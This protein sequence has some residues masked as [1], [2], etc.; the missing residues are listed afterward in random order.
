M[1]ATEAGFADRV[2]ER[3]R[4]LIG[5][6]LAHLL[7]L[8]AEE[9]DPQR[10]F[11]EQGLTSLLCEELRLGLQEQFGPLS[12][13]LLFE[14]P[15]LA[16]LAA[17]LAHMQEPSEAASEAVDW[18]ALANPEDAIAI[19]G[20]A[21]RFP[22][23][24]NAEAFWQLLIEGR[25]C[26]VPIP[27]E[28]W[29]DPTLSR[30]GAL[31][32]ELDRF[33][34]L[35]FQISPAE[36]ERLDPQVKLALMCAWETLEHG[37]FA[38][39]QRRA[40][41]LIGHYI[42]VTW[43][44]FSLLHHE[45]GFL[46]GEYLGPGAHY[47]Q[48]ANRVS[49]AF[50]LGGPSLAV[51]SACS[52]S[53]VAIH[54]ACQALRSGD[55]SLALA[56]G[57]NLSLH[58]SKYA[59]LER[60]GFL[61]GD[62]RCKPFAAAADGYVP[63]E[64]VGYVLLQP[65]AAAQASGAPVLAVIRGSASNHGGR[66]TGY[67]V[68]N[69]RAHAKVIALACQRA[70]LAPSYI[71]Y[72]EAH[73]TGTALGDP[74]EV[75]GLT[76]VLGE[77]PSRSC[78]LGSVKGNIGHL[79][80]AA[81]VAGLI[82]LVLGMR[83]MRLPATVNQ[84]PVSP[85]I[86]FENTRFRLIREAEAWPRVDQV[87]GL[88]SF[89]A[90]GSNAHVIL[91][92]AP[93][94][95]PPAA[96]LA[97]AWVP[98]SAR[99]SAGLRLL[100]MRL[101]DELARCGDDPARWPGFVGSLR[102]GRLAWHY[103]L[104][105]VA[106]NFAACLAALNAF[107]AGTE[108]AW[109]EACLARHQITE[110]AGTEQTSMAQWLAGEVSH[111]NA[112][113]RF[114]WL[115]LPTTPFELERSWLT[116]GGALYEPLPRLF[117]ALHPLLDYADN[118]RERGLYG[119]RF[120]LDCYAL[121]EHHVAGTPL[122]PGV[123]HLE[124][125]WQAA[126]RWT[127]NEALELRDVLFQH[128]IRLLQPELHVQ[129]R[130]EGSGPAL[131][132]A[133][134][135]A[136]DSTH[137]D[138]SSGQVLPAM[139][140]Q[141]ALRPPRPLAQQMAPETLY[142]LFR[143]NGILQ[144]QAFQVVVAFSWNDDEAWAELRIPPSRAGEFSDYALPSP[145]L[146]GAVQ[147]AMAHLFA[148]R[149][150]DC[151]RVPFHLERLQRFG[152]APQ[153]VFASARPRPDHPDRYEVA[154]TDGQGR[155]WILM[156]GL[157]LRPYREHGE[158]DPGRAFHLPS[159]RAIAAPA[160]AAPP[161][162]LLV[163]CSAASWA[164]LSPRLTS[165]GEVHWTGEQAL[166]EAEAPA[167]V[168]ANL[169][170]KG[171]PE[172]L[173]VLGDDLDEAAEAV[174]AVLFHWCQAALARLPRLR[175]I[176]CWREREIKPRHH[177]VTGLLRSLTL[178]H[179]AF[180]GTTLCLDEASD[181]IKALQETLADPVSV[182]VRYQSGQRQL[183][184]WSAGLPT[185][186]Q[187]TRLVVPGQHYLITGGLGGLGQLFA[188]AMLAEGA[189]LTLFGRTVRALDELG[190]CLG[191]DYDATR[192][193]YRAVDLTQPVELGEQLAAACAQ[194][195]PLRGVLHAAGVLDDGFLSHKR[196]PA[197]ARV[198]APKVA[199]TEQLDQACAEQPLDYF[200]MFSSVSGV[201]GNLGQADYAYANA[202]QDAYAELREDMRGRGLRHGRSLAIAWPY[203]R[204]GGMRLD[205]A[206]Q[207]QLARL[208][209]LHGLESAHGLR[210]CREIL[211]GTAARVLVMEGDRDRIRQVLGQLE[212]GSAKTPKLEAGLACAGQDPHE[213]A[214]NWLCELVGAELKLSTEQLDPHLPLDR[215]GLDSITLIGLSERLE[216]HLGAL[217]RTLFFEWENL[218]DGANWLVREHG[219]RFQAPTAVPEPP[220]ALDRAGEPAQDKGDQGAPE[221]IAIIGMTARL[222]L[223]ADLERFWENLCAGRDCIGE[224]PASRWASEAYYREDGDGYGSTR[225][226]W[227]GFLEDVNAFDAAFFRI[228]P[229][230]AKL[231]DPEE[232]L[233]LEQT[234]HTLE[235]A[236]LTRADLEA[237][238]R[239][240]GGEVGVYVGC[241][242]RHYGLLE[243]DAEDQPRLELG[244]YWWLANR[245]SWLYDLQGPSMAIDTACASA[246]TAVHLACESLARGECGMAFAGAVNLSL[247]PH[248]Y[249]G[250]NQLGLLASGRQSRGLGT[251]DG[252]IPGEGV[253][254]LLL[255][256]YA[257]ALED[258]DRVRA[259]IR[260]SFANHGGHTS[261]LT[262]PNARAHARLW[263]RLFER[264]GCQPATIGYVETA[265][266]GSALG[267]ALELAG[268]ARAFA[269][270]ELPAAS[271]AIGTVK[272]NLGHLEAASGISQLAK[273]VLQLEHRWLVPTIHAEPLNPNLQ[274]ER[275]PFALVREGRPW[276]E[277]GR[278]RALVTSI[279]AGGTNTALIVDAAPILL[280]QPSAVGRWVFP[281]SARSQAALDRL[282]GALIDWLERHPEAA[283]DQVAHTLQIGREAFAERLAVVASEHTEL[284]AKLRIAV[285]GEGISEPSTGETE[286]LAR[287]WLA[288]EQVDWRAS[289]A[290]RPRLSLPLYPFERIG[291]GP[292]C[293]VAAP[294][295]VVQDKLPSPAMDTADA[296]GEAA[297][298]S[299]CVGEPGRREDALA[300]VREQVLVVLGISPDQELESQRFEDLGI[301]SFLAL[302]L[303]RAFERVFGKLRKTLFFETFSIDELTDT[304]LREHAARLFEQLKPEQTLAT[305]TSAAP[306]ATSSSA[307]WVLRQDQVE[308]EPE[309]RALMSGLERWQDEFTA[310][311]A[312][313]EIAPLLFI[314]AERA[315]CFPFN[316]EG[317][318]VL[319]FGYLGPPEQYEALLEE[320]MSYCQA[321]AL[322]VALIGTR[323]IA[324]VAGRRF[325]ATPFGVMQRLPPLAEFSLEGGAMR[326]LRYMVQHCQ[327]EGEVRTLSYQPGSDPAVDQAIVDLIDRWSASKSM[328]N[329]LV[330]KTRAEILSAS[331]PRRHRIFISYQQERPLN[332]IIVSRLGQGSWLMDLEFYPPHMTLGG[333]ETTIVQIAEILRGEGASQLS[334][335]ATWGALVGTSA[336]ACPEWLAQLGELHQRG[337]FNG[338]GNLQFKN[339][340]RP[341]NQDIFLCRPEGQTGDITDIILMISQP[342]EAP[343]EEEPH[344]VCSGDRA[345][346]AGADMDRL[347][348]LAQHG[349]N[350]MRLPDDRVEIDLV[351]DS[352]SQLEQDFI[353]VRLSEL[354]SQLGEVC[355]PIAILRGIFPFQHLTLVGSGRMAE[356]FLCDALPKQSSHV[357][358][359]LLFPTWIVHQIGNGFTPV[360]LPDARAFDHQD[361]FIFKGNLDLEGVR[362]RLDQLA[363]AYC[364]VELGNNATGGYPVSLD[365]LRQLRALLAPRGI[366]LLLDGTRILENAVFIQRHEAGCQGDSIWKI[367]GDICA[368]AD[369]MT[370]SLCKD[371]C[372]NVGGFVATN[373]GALHAQIQ[374]ATSTR[375]S[376][377]SAIDRRLIG[378]G[379]RG[380]ATIERLV[381][382]RMAA[383]ARLHADLAGEGVPVLHPHGGHCVV[384]DVKRLDPHG[385]E[386]NPLATTLAWLYLHT[387]IRAGAHSVGMQRQSSLN[388]LV[389]LAL[390]VGLPEARVAEIG[391]AMVK[392]FRQ[393]F[394][395]PALVHDRRVP[396]LFGEARATY[397]LERIEAEVTP[398]PPPEQA[399]AAPTAEWVDPHESIAIVGLAGRYP[400]AENL[401]IFWRNLVE[402][403]DCVTAMPGDRWN[404]RELAGDGV[405]DGHLMGGFIDGVTC[406][407]ALFFNISPREARRMDPQERLFLEIAWET[408]EEAGYTPES[409]KQGCESDQIG[410][411]VGATWSMYQ[412]LDADLA[413]SGHGVGANSWLWAIANRVSYVMG[414]GGPSLV[415]D[416]ACSSSLA[417]L[418]MARKAILEGSCTAALAGGV[419]L[420]LHPA[421]RMIVQEAGFLAED[422]RC[423]AFGRGGSGYVPGE[424]VGAVLLRRLSLA[425]RD[426][427]HIHAVIRSSTM[428][429]GGRT[430]GFTV[431]NTLAQGELVR[432]ALREA[433]TPAASI[434]YLEAHGTGTA[435]GDPIEV[436]G[437]CQAF[438]GDADRHGYCALGSVK[439]NIG[440]LE[441]A[442]GIAGL[443][444]VLLQMRHRLIAPSLH[445]GELNEY[446]DF[447]NSP[448]FVPQRTCPWQPERDL[449]EGLPPR[450]GISSFGAGGANVHLILEAAPP[451]SRRGGEGGPV[452]LVYSARS[453]ERLRMLVV[454]HRDYLAKGLSRG[455]VPDLADMAFTLQTGRQALSQRLAVV[456]VDAAVALAQLEAYLSGLPATAERLSGK[457]RPNHEAQAE[458]EAAFESRDLKSLARL[459]VEGVTLDWRRL[460]DA[461]RRLSLPTYPFAR[462]PHWLGEAR[463]AGPPA[464]G[465]V[466]KPSGPDRLR[467]TLSASAAYI[468]DHCVGGQHL[469][470]GVAYLELARAA[471]VVA[472]TTPT[473]LSRIAW[474][475]PLRL[476]Q[477]EVA[478]EV[479]LESS[480]E[481]RLAFTV[482]SADHEHARG[483]LDVLPLAPPQALDLAALERRLDT[484]ESGA[485][486]YARFKACGFDY[487]PSF[488]AI[489]RLHRRG[490]EAL[491]L[492]AAPPAIAAELPS[493]VCHPSFLD[494]CLHLVIALLPQDGSPHLPYGLGELTLYRDLASAR[495][496]HIWASGE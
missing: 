451:L 256:P 276:S 472:G 330:P 346:L 333:L 465:L 335:G 370:A 441:A 243:H 26:A 81:G 473:C 13:T 231:M 210:A 486:C 258:G 408:L 392:A 339:K 47:W 92:A 295:A 128:P 18:E 52:S 118:T 429:H 382:A 442:A 111:F 162:R 444:K 374:A 149:G 234:W 28:R 155:P 37:N 340:F 479:R 208:F 7:G 411:Y 281:L 277:A 257:R 266:N 21:C 239:R 54:L 49:F 209:G 436:E 16:A 452:L 3:C 448:F 242:Y 101:R 457:A 428:N 89:G 293:V 319:V 450:A 158:L 388:D 211:A 305:P 148:T 471:A 17:H 255:K 350:P 179:P 76:E 447:D 309:A 487:G 138:Y 359:N 244:S 352:W 481:G 302:K 247:H 237:Y 122:L 253:G 88:S 196:W 126:A 384:I 78:G 378:L 415:V 120:G 356:S 328:V 284:L 193:S 67:T 446:I 116:S 272:S 387:G 409:L 300:W 494:S 110:Q 30:H 125:A 306:T 44:E 303:V 443:T 127:G 63:G 56:G 41:Q 99:S 153:K 107:L 198:L 9:L 403:R 461:G 372:L 64:G 11:Y 390:P 265:A 393:P 275:T 108:G 119:K 418:H 24:A 187:P 189:S 296:T 279:G 14:H 39:P 203:W 468:R 488:Q 142:G 157:G 70:G 97:A 113:A 440:H 114:P 183:L 42:G 449:R 299:V 159:W 380:R 453:E 163:H 289:L 2:S 72:I 425:L 278:W 363:V 62:G 74:V 188:R 61:A 236:A 135:P 167:R 224:V 379:L 268:L 45:R 367:V 467:C 65:L 395:V 121:K 84:E 377:L 32:E 36:A 434:T 33:D 456:C 348:L 321:Q 131:R 219:Q 485:S 112:P 426:G 304:L 82:K 438:R 228:A 144:K 109:Q 260:G 338:H 6:R 406:F 397:R 271:V 464:P 273:V 263:R 201:L 341:S 462:V 331:L 87:A 327:R 140:E 482:S 105:L 90:G 254:M 423:R 394:P 117:T 312:T 171:T 204:Q 102:Y 326:R 172:V 317:D 160:A 371:F 285:I 375:G 213:R 51:D 455:Q 322:R 262:V 407:D 240:P 124:M 480:G 250:L 73:G 320:L 301:D 176:H 22:Q 351:T 365:N 75:R 410:V 368:L 412:L 100:A 43:H 91:T 69:P 85:R 354:Q 424:G 71:K 66:A 130:V 29:H 154:L 220:E 230:E 184:G 466:F 79:E 106:D 12:S 492:L 173:L 174:A 383:V 169:E 180:V 332:T 297:R 259:V 222:P 325:T 68:P 96:A 35:F 104:A 202:F 233:L 192:V 214:L 329:P 401:D 19:V 212:V 460:G 129:C 404:Y 48:V 249:L 430:A 216:P 50:D 264:S 432:R 229:T 238:Q 347:A 165:W 475:R 1:P 206:G 477:G 287:R 310:S 313:R 235:D 491:A 46:A 288:G 156:E 261:G 232:R 195:G 389:R 427:D 286:A 215:F 178:E 132:F 361:P 420:D 40:G 267:D 223:A 414:F 484:V 417:A 364:C 311:R 490:R 476:E 398:H 336:N 190:Q 495:W 283:L 59:W 166:G 221:G 38:Q 139:A 349:Y 493:L 218:I 369:G 77:T 251:G 146:D 400:M 136:Q 191:A 123:C 360:E 334:L 405:P 80:A 413:R 98:V 316:R 27:S 197:F 145:L 8:P 225:Q 324:A 161:A 381:R 470:P 431:P 274:L 53:L 152:P 175:L 185:A 362:Q 34:P 294:A 454:R 134:V 459:W 298:A 323:A 115:N 150:H 282:T 433:G 95:E 5:D 337:V 290:S 143:E 366:P 170:P 94:T 177:A 245:I 416:T 435:L 246:L 483:Q 217:P 373:D 489:E 25:D 181:L 396:G 241:M 199:G 226:K 355:D 93:L 399:V 307:P 182:Q 343:S 291:H 23:A 385:E 86:P 419:N 402:G 137:Y 10:S 151:L 308:S 292:G 474:L 353:R 168:L 60:S 345:R 186:A 445:S 358:Q 248:K 391:T 227:G 270:P 439:T 141:P 200:L 376:G 280:A 20:L 252:Y 207:N 57:V 133:L 463:T 31:L 83:H 357:L 55:C 421:K 386:E 103:R 147:T 194:F 318:L 422:G 342:P 164:A 205:E 478:L 344:S 496:V 314:G 269:E 469:L 315:A 437:L 15:N 58:P 458:A 4:R